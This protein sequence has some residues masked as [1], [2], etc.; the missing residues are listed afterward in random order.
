MTV[1]L[2][3]SLP[4]LDAAPPANTGKN[5]RAALA[6]VADGNG[7]SAA[8]IRIAREDVGTA[9]LQGEISVAFSNRIQL[10]HKPGRNPVG[11]P[12]DSEELARQLAHQRAQAL[13]HNTSLRSMVEQELHRLPAQGWGCDTMRFNLG[14]A[15]DDVFSVISD[16]TAC[17]GKAQTSCTMCGGS[18]STTTTLT[19]RYSAE[20]SFTLWRQGADMTALAAAEKLG[21]KKMASD[22]LADIFILPLV[23]DGTRLKSSCVAVLPL[24]KIDFS[25]EGRFVTAVVAGKKGQ[26][27]SLDPILDKFIKPGVA[28]LLK[29]SRG[30]LAL[31]SLVSMAMK[32]RLVRQTLQSVLIYPRGTVYKQLQRD[33]PIGVSDKYLRAAV[34]YASSA[35]DAL[36]IEPRKQGLRLGFVLSLI[37]SAVYIYALRPLIADT[38]LAIGSDGVV[39]TLLSLLTVILIRKRAATRI[40]AM[41]RAPR[42]PSVLPPAKGE[43]MRAPVMVVLAFVLAGL[44]LPMR[45]AYLNSVAETA[46]AALGPLLSS[47]MSD[48]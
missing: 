27:V 47:V 46:T 13:V 48:Q 8:Q 32:Y 40:V 34:K 16:C 5:A 22:N 1:S 14:N 43:G 28:A 26:I 23:A 31:D 6:A 17:T 39:L 36:M 25:L 42:A 3:T 33:Y 9:R 35:I 4:A 29:L 12:T 38:L 15:A 19:V 21:I 10:D 2:A 7:L 11:T 41:T 37:V 45:P 20:I 18:G 30:P 44:C 24:A